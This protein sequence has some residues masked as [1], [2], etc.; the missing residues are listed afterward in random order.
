[1]PKTEVQ[2]TE[3][4]EA[5]DEIEESTSEESVSLEK[6]KRKINYIKTPARELAFEK[7]RQKRAENIELKK[8]QKEELLA[9]KNKELIQ[10]KQ[11]LEEKLVKKSGKKLKEE[12]NK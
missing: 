8:K 9:E 7:A 10:K 6:P 11:I 4:T 5:T 12:I 3:E 1:M 2:E